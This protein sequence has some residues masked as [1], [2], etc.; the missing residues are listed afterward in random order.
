MAACVS[1]AGA[2]P[3]PRRSV[4]TIRESGSHIGTLRCVRWKSGTAGDLD[5]IELE[6]DRREGAVLVFDTGPARFAKSLDELERVP[7]RFDAG[8]TGRWVEL[9]CVDPALDTNS[10]EIRHTLAASAA[11][12]G[13]YYLR[14]VQK[15]C[16][17]AWT[18]PVYVDKP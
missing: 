4:S 17:M 12:E 15:D 14:V 8:A 18:S 10:V 9:E 3:R 16:E 2:S 11:V 5:G 7:W 13:A 6:I 1:R